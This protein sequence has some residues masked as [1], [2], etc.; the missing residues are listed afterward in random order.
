MEFIVFVYYL[1]VVVG[2]IFIINRKEFPEWYLAILIYV[3]FKLLFNYRHCTLS[4]V[5]CL[6]RGVKKENGYLY[7]FLED[8]VDLRCRPD[9][10]TFYM[11]S[12]VLIII[13]HINNVNNN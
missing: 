2:L 12:V 13:N 8:L 11:V 1:I 5:E 3:N 10:N 4:R 9:I 6:A 7:N